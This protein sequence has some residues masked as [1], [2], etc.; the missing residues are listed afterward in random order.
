MP[1]ATLHRLFTVVA[2]ILA[3]GFSPLALA[4]VRVLA[5]GDSNTWGWKPTRDGVSTPR[6][7]DSERWAGVM[8]KAL[9]ADYVVEVNGLIARTLA[10]DQ[11]SGIGALKG[12]DFN[13]LRRLDLA[14]M[15]TGPIHLLMV[16]LGTNDMIDSL[17]RSPS[18]IAAGLASLAAKAR[19]GTSAHGASTHPRL[20]VVIPPPFG[21]PRQ[22]PFNDLFGPRAIAKSRLLADAMQKEARRLHLLSFDAGSVV[23]LDS[24]DG[25]HLT[26]EGHRKLGLA[27]AAEVTRLVAP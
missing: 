23:T 5:Y 25:V 21:D 17:H 11:T 6:Y 9:G 14:L 18:Q 27:L 4:Q 12:P 15:Q 10:V 1:N 22:G 24:V 26:E 8:Q 16:M 19:S 2:L 3:F 7:A 20:L 13:G